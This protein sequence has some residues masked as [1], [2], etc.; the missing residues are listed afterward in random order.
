MMEDGKCEEAGD[1]TRDVGDCDI[2]V[3]T[4]DGKSEEADDGN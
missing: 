3:M 2:V 4:D 1:D